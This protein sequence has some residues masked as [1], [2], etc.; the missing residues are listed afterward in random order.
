[1]RLRDVPNVA[2]RSY[3][4]DDVITYWNR[5]ATELYGY[6]AQEAIGRTITDLIVPEAL[7]PESLQT[8]E[9]MFER[10]RVN[11]PREYLFHTKKALEVYV[12]CSHT[13]LSRAGHAPEIISFDIDMSER[14][15]AQTELRIAAAAF[16][17]PDSMLVLDPQLRVLRI[18]QAFKV[19]LGYSHEEVVGESL[20][21]LT[22]EGGDSALHEELYRL[23]QRQGQWSGEMWL[24][25]RRLLMDR[26]RQA[27]ENSQFSQRW[28]AVL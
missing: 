19:R 13:Y 1:M 28:G 26:M 5:G 3:G 14:N 8:I 25:N 12:Y 20:A 4:R 18:N 2:V 22:A 21:Q 7:T 17:S 16:E 27:L 9:R 24:P 6:A 11:P 10:Q 15:R 23:L